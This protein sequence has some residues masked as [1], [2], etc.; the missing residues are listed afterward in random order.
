MLPFRTYSIILC[1]HTEEAR[2]DAN[3]SLIFQLNMIDII[4]HQQTTS[5]YIYY[6]YVSSVYIIFINW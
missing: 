3:Y 5:L 1:D 4:A 2:Y 6:M